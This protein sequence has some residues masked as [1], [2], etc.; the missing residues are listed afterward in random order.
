VQ[1]GF[2]AIGIEREAEYVADIV[3]RMR[4]HVV[5]E[6]PTKKEQAA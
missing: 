1:E 4:L 5:S 3:Q 2:Q 6:L